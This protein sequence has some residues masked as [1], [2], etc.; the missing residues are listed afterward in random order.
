LTKIARQTIR[1]TDLEHRGRK[2]V[3]QLLPKCVC[4]WPKG[5]TAHTYVTYDAI[6]DLGLKIEARRRG[7]VQV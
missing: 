4:I 2:L 6:Y 3:V 7:K 1:E 5:T